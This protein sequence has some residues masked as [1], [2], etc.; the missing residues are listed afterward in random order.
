M[1]GRQCDMKR[2]AYGFWGECFG[3]NKCFGQRNH[4]VSYL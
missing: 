4:F 1:H 3:I 2:I